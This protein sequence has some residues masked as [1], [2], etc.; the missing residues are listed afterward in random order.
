MFSSPFVSSHVCLF[1]L[2]HIYKN[3][4][5]DFCYPLLNLL[6]LWIVY[7]TINRYTKLDKERLMLSAGARLAAPLEWTVLKP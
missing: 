1:F 7:P 6:C 5:C 3:S 4:E 2:T